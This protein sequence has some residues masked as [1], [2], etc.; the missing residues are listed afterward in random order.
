M[1]P[2]IHEWTLFY[3]LGWTDKR[4]LPP[5]IR[6]LV[7]FIHC[8]GNLCL[9][10]CFSLLQERVI[11]PLLSNGLFQLV[12]KTCFSGL[13]ASNGVFQ[14]S[15]IMSQYYIVTYF[16]GNTNAEILLWNHYLYPLY[17]LPAR[18]GFLHYTI[19]DTWFVKYCIRASWCAF[20]K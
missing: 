15:G 13:L 18:S 7:C 20:N 11:E 16:P 14:L 8:H 6:V 17:F 5:I 12:T 10:S 9:G 1:N 4:A 3:N 2:W 19:P